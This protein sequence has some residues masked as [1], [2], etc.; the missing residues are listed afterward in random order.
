MHSDCDGLPVCWFAA[1]KVFR[2]PVKVTAV[3]FQLVKNGFF[4]IGKS[5]GNTSSE[6]AIRRQQQRQGYEC[7]YSPRRTR[8]ADS[9][10]RSSSSWSERLRSGQNALRRQQWGR[11]GDAHSYNAAD[12]K[13]GTRWRGSRQEEPGLEL[14][15]SLTTETEPV[16]TDTL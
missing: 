1:L 2:P 6:A 5:K 11:R 14:T 9:F 12:N 16:V 7:H 4:N 15:D 13:I 8:A 10:K 3:V